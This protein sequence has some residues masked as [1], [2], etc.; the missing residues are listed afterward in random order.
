LQ[1][2]GVVVRELDDLRGCVERVVRDPCWSALEWRAACTPLM[3]Q[4]PKIRQSLTHL[5]EMRASRWPRTDWAVR[6]SAA[7]ENFERRLIDVCMSMSAL[8]YKE[9]SD[10]D[11]VADLSSDGIKLVQA[12]DDLRSLIVS[13]YP[14]VDYI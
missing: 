13:E 14:M 8:G 10:I 12:A 9:T 11:M 7:R 5:A 4:A 3:L 6:L 2:L 1:R